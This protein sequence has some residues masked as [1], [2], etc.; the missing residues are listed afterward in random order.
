MYFFEKSIASFFLKD[1]E[2]IF[3]VRKFFVDSVER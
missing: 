3:E 2:G 1:V